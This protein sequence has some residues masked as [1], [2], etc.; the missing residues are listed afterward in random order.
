M[1]FHQWKRREVV[2][3][4]GGAAAWPLAVRAQQSGRMRR[5]GVLV[6]TVESDPRGLEYITAFAQGWRNWAGP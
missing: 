4:L 3:L 5:I 6:S 1:H 2:S